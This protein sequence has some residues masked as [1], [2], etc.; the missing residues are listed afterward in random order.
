M[1]TALAADSCGVVQLAAV[2]LQLAAVATVGV[3]LLY[4]NIIDNNSHKNE[5]GKY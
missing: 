4:K 3:V 1:G 2:L 5:V